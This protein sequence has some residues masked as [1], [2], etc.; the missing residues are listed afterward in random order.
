MLDISYINMHYMALKSQEKPGCFGGEWIVKG[1]VKSLFVYTITM[2]SLWRSVES[3][4]SKR[5]VPGSTAA[6]ELLRNNLRQV[7]RTL[8]PLPSNSISWYRCKNREGSGRLWMR[9][10]LL[11]ITLSVSSLTYV[12]THK[13][14]TRMSQSC[15][16]AMLTNGPLY[17]LPYFTMWSSV[18]SYGR[19]QR[20]GMDACSALSRIC[21]GLLQQWRLN[22]GARV[23]ITK[24]KQT[25]VVTL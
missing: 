22:E 18:L 13:R 24:R 21:L 4:T 19:T 23:N 14:H 11:S 20:H 10:G 9:C 12:N 15:E 25:A 5:E 1:R 2:W 16:R 17:T 6:L 3:L 7:V 8:V